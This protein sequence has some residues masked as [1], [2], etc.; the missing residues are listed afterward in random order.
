MTIM[1]AGV[2]RCSQAVA[3]ASMLPRRSIH[4]P[5]PAPSPLP[6]SWGS[7]GPATAYAWWASIPGRS[8]RLLL[9]ID[10]G[11]IAWG[12]IEEPVGV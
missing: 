10:G 4:P 9:T 1:L 3:R 8:R 7:T 2:F 5:K 12:G 6:T 11:W